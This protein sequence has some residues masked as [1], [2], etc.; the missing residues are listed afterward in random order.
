MNGKHL[1][2]GKQLIYAIGVM[3][4]SI[5]INLISVILVYLYVP[6][7]GSGLPN[8]I[9]QAA[10]FGIFNAM[11]LITTSGRFM[12]I[13]YD[14]FI[15]QISDRSKNPKGRRTPFMK[16]A[17]VPSFLF[18][19]MVFYPLQLHEATV[20]IFWLA[21]A[22][23][24]F[25]VSTT[26]FIIPYTALLPELAPTSKDKVRLASWQSAGYVFG[27]GIASNAF[28]IAAKIQQTFATSALVGLQLT[29][30]ALAF[31]AAIC[32]AITAFGINEKKYSI[33]KPS[34][35]PLKLALKQ[36]LG[37]R[38]F[39]LFI[40]ADFSYFIAITLITSGLVYFIEVLLGLDKKM[41]NELM[42]AM[43]LVSFIFYPVVNYLSAKIGKKPLVIV[44]LLLL[45][46][47][48]GG[49]Y[50][51]G[52]PAIDPTAQIFALICIAAIPLASLNILPVAI[53]AEIIEDD[54]KK[55]GA[56]K[57]AMYFAVRYFFS[58][59][60]QTAGLALFSMMLIYGKDPGHDFGI[61]LNGIVGLVLCVTAS[62][63]FTRFREKRPTRSA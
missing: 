55:T 1:P 51:L 47:V 2:A 12:D 62:A 23:A 63:I 33:S 60:A 56:N 7:A 46:V 21:F 11:A 53:L 24:G 43:V 36:T 61:R 3:G 41:G 29:V 6:P 58:K 16:A 32:M 50:F 14:P 38:N 42:I 18:C 20:N 4:S 13:V 27:I 19:C 26:T 49:V 30:F 39:R 22:L 15:A 40:V 5:M 34:D 31:F 37:N 17:I 9:P 8:I 44:S 45:A 54:S 35:I 52:K 10:I 59:I 28:N 48:F 57:E 25:F